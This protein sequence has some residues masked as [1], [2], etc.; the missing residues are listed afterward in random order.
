MLAVNAIPRPEINQHHLP[1]QDSDVTGS[2]FI[3]PVPPLNEGSWLLGS[4]I[5]TGWSFTG[6]AVGFAS[7]KSVVS[8]RSATPFAPFRSE[9]IPVA[10]NTTAASIATPAPAAAFHQRRFCS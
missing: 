5:T 8:R 6:A 1:S 7:V 10:L 2:P 9:V 3:H 4:V